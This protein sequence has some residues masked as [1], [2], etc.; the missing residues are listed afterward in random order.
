MFVDPD[1]WLTSD[2][3]PLDENAAF[4]NAVDVYCHYNYP[5]NQGVYLW[6]NTNCV[7]CQEETQHIC[8]TILRSRTGHFYARTADWDATNGWQAADWPS[9]NTPDMLRVW[10]LSGYRDHITGPCDWMGA[11][12]KE[13]IVALTN[14][15]LVD[16]PCGCEFS[17]EKFM[18]DREEMEMNSIDVAMAQTT[19]GSA[20]RGAVQAYSY[21]KSLPPLGKGG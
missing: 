4:L 17:V 12:V 20:A 19:F 16:A 1:E 9:C 10:Y 15:Y 18:H 5:I 6:R 8:A 11:D 7:P 2:P 3:I 14:V 13:A 21:I